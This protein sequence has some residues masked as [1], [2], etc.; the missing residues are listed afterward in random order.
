[1]TRI[2]TEE[3]IR[4]IQDWLQKIIEEIT[5]NGMSIYANILLHDFR[6]DEPD[7][8]LEETV[9][10]IGRTPFYALRLNMRDELEHRGDKEVI[11]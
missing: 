2:S 11:K 7:E 8:I 3:K 10:A 5:P 4:R 1:M 9:E 6:G